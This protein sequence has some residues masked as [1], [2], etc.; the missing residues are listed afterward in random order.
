VTRLLFVLV[1]LSTGCFS[2]A[3]PPEL[4]GKADRDASTSTTDKGEDTTSQTE[5]DA[6]VDGDTDADT[7]VDTDADADTDADTDVDTDADVDTGSR[8]ACSEGIYC[9]DP[10]RECAGESAVKVFENPGYCVDDPELGAMCEYLQIDTLPCEDGTCTEDGVCSNDPC[11]G[12]TC[13]QPT[14]RRCSE[15]GSSVWAFG[16]NSSE[17]GTCEAVDG[18]PT[19]EYQ[20]FEVPCINECINNRCQ[21]QP[22]GGLV[23]GTPPASYCDGD[24]DLIE[25][26]VDNFN[27]K[28]T[29]DSCECAYP[30]TK[31]T[32]PHICYQGRCA[33]PE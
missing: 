23:C 16:G 15:D 12:I 21:D 6:D 29:A 32:C 25:F 31:I 8:S 7:D 22:C 19:C 9:Y 4:I 26:D 3:A 11:V 2:L 24:R 17:F 13:L 5:T 27:F 10:P 18:L 14:E 33:D 1:W 20:E 28:Q 30:A